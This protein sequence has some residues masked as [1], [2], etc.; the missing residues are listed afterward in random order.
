MLLTFSLTNIYQLYILLNVVFVLFFLNFTLYYI[1]IIGTF[2]RILFLIIESFIDENED[3]QNHVAIDMEILLSFI[4]KD[5]NAE[6]CITT[7]LTSNRTLLEGPIG[8]KTVERFLT[9]LSNKGKCK[10]TILVVIIVK[11]EM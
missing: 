7:M 6:R 9:L 5:V 3:N 11:I 10:C 8:Q 1:Y 4:D 2:L